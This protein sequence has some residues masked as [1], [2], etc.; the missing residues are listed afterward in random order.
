MGEHGETGI[1]DLTEGAHPCPGG[2]SQ[3]RKE[4]SVL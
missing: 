4:K 1:P 2:E 3:E